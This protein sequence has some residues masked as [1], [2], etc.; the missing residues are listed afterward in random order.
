MSD[1]NSG[2]AT[3][4]A[5]AMCWHQWYGATSRVRVCVRVRGHAGYHKSR[6]GAFAHPAPAHPEPRAFVADTGP[7]MYECPHCDG[8]GGIHYDSR[9]AWLADGKVKR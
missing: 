1:E 4:S 3:P 6:G 2:R 7:G 5:K 8:T 9:A